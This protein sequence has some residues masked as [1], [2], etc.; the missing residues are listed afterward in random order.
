EAELSESDDLEH[1]IDRAFVDLDARQPALAEYL[2]EQID[3]ITDET[4]QALGHFLGVA[5]HEAFSGAFGKRLSCVDEASVAVARGSLEADEEL[6]RGS[7][8]EVLESDDVVAISQPHMLAFVREQLDAVLE[9][10]EDGDASDVDL[11]SVH[12]VYRA[13]LIEIIALSQAVEAPAGHV[14]RR[15]N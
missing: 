6:R 11:E 7:P 12:R 5:V 4:A 8:D 10:D 3:A 1:R 9:P 14:R 15:A 13:V 2:S